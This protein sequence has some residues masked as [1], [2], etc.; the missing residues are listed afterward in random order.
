M[1]E[2][3]IAF[4][5]WGVNRWLRYTGVRL[6]VTMWD[7]KGERPPASTKIGLMWVGLPGS[8]GWKKWQ[9]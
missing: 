8:K 7:G 9:A 5:L 4:S 2:P 1:S 6:F 3:S